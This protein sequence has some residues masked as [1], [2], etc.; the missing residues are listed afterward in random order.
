MSAGLLVAPHL[1]MAAA[2]VYLEGDPRRWRAA[3]PEA[4]AEADGRCTSW[5]RTTVA[6]S[7][8]SE[9]G[10]LRVLLPQLWVDLTHTGRGAD[11]ATSPP[12]DGLLTG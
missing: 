11:G 8:A 5:R 10:G 9:K 3:G 4:V 1:R 7:T 12:G 2:H 6:C